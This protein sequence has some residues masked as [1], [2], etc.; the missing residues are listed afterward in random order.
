MQ[1]RFDYKNHRGET[2]PRTIQFIGIIFLKDPGYGYQP[3]WFVHG[4]CEDKNEVRS[5]ALCNILLPDGGKYY[6]L[7]PS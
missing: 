2:R 4:V 3:G 7:E 1:M 6:L 5:F